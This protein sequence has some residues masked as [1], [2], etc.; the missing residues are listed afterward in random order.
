[1]L[2]WFKVI[3][4]DKVRFKRRK[5][6]KVAKVGDEGPELWPSDLEAGPILTIPRETDPEVILN[7]GKMQ[8]AADDTLKE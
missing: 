5:K 7:S 8:A 4:P 2:E 6:V 3:D 1:M